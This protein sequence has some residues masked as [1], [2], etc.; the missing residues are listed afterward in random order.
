MQDEQRHFARPHVTFVCSEARRSFDLEVVFLSFVFVWAA[1]S[2]VE[3]EVF[4][5]LPITV[6]YFELVLMLFQQFPVR[7][8][9]V[10]F[11]Q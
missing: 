8:V 9:S 4:H 3:A 7:F 11:T 2:P 5:F 10:L 1:I 6:E